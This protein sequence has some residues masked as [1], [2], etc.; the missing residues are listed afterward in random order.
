MTLLDDRRRVQSLGGV[1]RRH[2]DVNNDD[3]GWIGIDAF[4]KRM[5]VTDLRRDIE[6]RIAQ[7]PGQPLT[8]QRSVVGDH[9][10]QGGPTRE[11]ITADALA[12]VDKHAAASSVEI[13]VTATD[14]LA[15]VECVTTEPAARQLI[16]VRACADS[17]IGSRHWAGNCW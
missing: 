17:P 6:P 14:D 7:H 12:N 16:R 10:P 5:R 9:H 15:V 11:R 2:P 1:G 8:E 13:E 3:I 4:Q